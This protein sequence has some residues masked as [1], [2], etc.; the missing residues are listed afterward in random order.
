MPKTFVRRVYS[1]WE[2]KC[3]SFSRRDRNSLKAKQRVVGVSNFVNVLI[4]KLIGEK[5][6]EEDFLEEK[7][8]LFRF[9]KNSESC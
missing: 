1:V 9:L 5:T 6:I 4:S 8:E 2:V 3:R 7:G